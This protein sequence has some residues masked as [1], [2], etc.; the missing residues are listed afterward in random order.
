MAIPPVPVREMI[1]ERIAPVNSLVIVK[2]HLPYVSSLKRRLPSDI[3]IVVIHCTELPDLRAARRYG[4]HI[5]YPDSGTGNSGHFYIERNGRIEEW[6]PPERVAHHVRGYNQRSIGIELV[7]RGRYPEWLDSRNQ[8]MT[9]PY[10][11]EQIGCLVRL[12]LH[13]GKELPGLRFVTGHE[14]LD[15]TKVPATD[16]PGKMIRRKQDPG[17]L[18]AWEDLLGQIELTYFSPG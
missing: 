6:V 18:F 1:P 13:L 10:A 15:T 16:N 5:Q 7:N 9:E 12:L 14:T 8:S 2:N 11:A 17:P 4:E 3:D